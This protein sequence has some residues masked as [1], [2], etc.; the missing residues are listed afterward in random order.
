[1]I[2]FS[3]AVFLTRSQDLAQHWGGGQAAGPCHKFFS[4]LLLGQ[5]I[6]GLASMYFISLDSPFREEDF[7]F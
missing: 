4:I 1:M 3:V 6:Y 5:K 7:L 2:Y